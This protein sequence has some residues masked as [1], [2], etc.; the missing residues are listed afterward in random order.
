MQQI[1]TKIKNLGPSTNRMKAALFAFLFVCSL[2]VLLA[3]SGVKYAYYQYTHVLQ[4]PLT[5]DENYLVGFAGNAYVSNID[6][7]NYQI[8]YQG[9]SN[10]EF[11]EIVSKVS[12]DFGDQLVGS[13]VSVEFL[14]TG[15][16]FKLVYAAGVALIVAW[17]L[18]YW[19]LT[20]KLEKEEGRQANKLFLA[21]VLSWVVIAVIDLGVL[22]L[23]S[24]FYEL[25]EVTFVIWGIAVM[26]MY[27][28]TCLGWYQL[29][30]RLTGSDLAM[31][32]KLN[33]ATYNKSLVL[34]SSVIGLALL[35][36]LGVVLLPEVGLL[37]LYMLFMSYA[38][39]ELPALFMNFR[40]RRP[41]IRRQSKATS[42]VESLELPKQDTKQKSATKRKRKGR[43][44]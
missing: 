9:I 2:V 42:K 12:S 33:L 22:S 43:R 32:F 17:I 1:I 21:V 13:F 30:I 24:M 38:I 37:L 28:L 25:Q 5:A 27:A 36:G 44:S 10:G 8:S 6:L 41:R 31:Q 11:Q 20:R 18:S 23:L 15:A 14:P 3:N 39:A 19:T 26:V 7:A 35:V 16:L 34:A 40:P 29:T 4:L